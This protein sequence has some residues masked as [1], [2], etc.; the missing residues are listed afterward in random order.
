MT[1][2]RRPQLGQ[3]LKGRSIAQGLPRPGVQQPLDPPKILAADPPHGRRLD[4]L[5]QEM[6]RE[7]GTTAAKAQSTAVSHLAVDVK[8]DLERIREQVAN[9]L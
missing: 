6:M 1:T 9:V 2:L 7:T 3:H 4:F 8:A 5:C